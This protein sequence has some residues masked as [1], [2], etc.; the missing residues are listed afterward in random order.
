MIKK[1]KVMFTGG[2]SSGHVTPSLPLISALQHKGADIFYVGSKKGIEHSIIKSLKISYYP[3]LVGK[4][5]RYWTWK[6]LL[7]P[8]RLLIGIVQSFLI[9]RKIKPDVIFSKGGFVAL[10]VVIAAKLNDIPTVIHESDLTPGLANRL[11]FPFAKLICI[12]FPSTLKYFKYSSKVLLTGMPIRDALLHGN[13]HKGLELCGFVD[14]LKPIL[15]IMGGGLGSNIINECIRRLINS[16]TE[17]FQVIHI[18]GKNKSDP[19]F[20]GIKNY[21]QFEYLQEELADI[22]AISDLVVSR[23]GA[24]SIYEILALKKPNILLPLSRK[25][26]RGDQ[27][28]NAKYFANLGF[29]KV[30]YFEEFSDEK[31]LRILFESYENLDQLKTQLNRFK[32]LNAT[33]IILHKLLNFTEL[34]HNTDN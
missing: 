26:S 21:K 33:Q 23:A 16:L 28:D 29:S 31:L 4:L 6:N 32:R 30:I 15:L 17:K 19:V 20:E 11:C 1:I 34:I 22:F 18:C 5:H 27:I 3:I 8:F 7:T 2:G 25:A 14:K 24:T 12:T 13:Y 10:P 9:C